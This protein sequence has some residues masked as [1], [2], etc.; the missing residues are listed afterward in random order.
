MEMEGLMERRQIMSHISMT[1]W[2]KKQ[3]ISIL[4]GLFVNQ[5]ILINQ[6]FS[7]ISKLW[8]RL[9][10]MAIIFRLSMWRLRLCFEVQVKE[11]AGLNG[12]GGLMERGE[13]N[14]KRGA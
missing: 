14:G 3:K 10:N 5:M 13:L 8:M 9:C 7:D 11:E 6:Y 2:I 1:K 4:S 12:E